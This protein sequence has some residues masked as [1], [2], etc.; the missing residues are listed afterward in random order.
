LILM[1]VLWIGAGAVG[2]W[3]AGRLARGNGFGAIG[4]IGA[5]IAGAFAGVFVFHAAGAEFDAAGIAGSVGVACIGAA[6]AVVIVHQLTG[7]RSG[8]RLWS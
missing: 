4:D 6:I 3:L 8:R 1:I 7:V 2:G 5:G